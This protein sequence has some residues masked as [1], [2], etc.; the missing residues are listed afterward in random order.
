MEILQTGARGERPRSAGSGAQI[1]I[2]CP[3][4]DHGEQLVLSGLREAELDELR[5]WFCYTKPMGSSVKILATSTSGER[6]SFSVTGNEPN[7]CETG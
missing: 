2:V 6:A 1:V 4:E 3:Q 5:E 7:G